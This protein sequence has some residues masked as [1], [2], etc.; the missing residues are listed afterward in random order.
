[1]NFNKR[2]I[3][4]DETDYQMQQSGIAKGGSFAYPTTLIKDGYMYIIYS[5]QKEIIE[6]TKFD[7]GQIGE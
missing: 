1:M 7:L 4:R 2:Y 6:V 3:I 5:K